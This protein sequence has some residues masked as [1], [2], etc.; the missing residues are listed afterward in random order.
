[1]D[2]SDQEMIDPSRN[3][4]EDYKMFSERDDKIELESVLPRN[5]GRRR[6]PKKDG[7]MVMFVNDTGKWSHCTRVRMVKMVKTKRWSCCDGRPAQ[8]EAKSG[9]E[10]F[11]GWSIGLESSLYRI[12]GRGL[13]NALKRED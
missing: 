6:T 2:L 4:N 9:D 7:K 1:M 10:D 5:W 8:M 11:M 3:E 12:Y 13:E